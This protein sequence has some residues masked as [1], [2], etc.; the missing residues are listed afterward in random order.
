MPIY[1]T[2]DS[3]LCRIVSSLT[4]WITIS[5][6]G[7]KVLRKAT[8]ESGRPTLGHGTTV[9]LTDRLRERLCEYWNGKGEECGMELGDTVTVRS[10][11]RRAR[12]V[13]QIGGDR[14]RV[15]FTPEPM[16][17][18]IDR[19]TPQSEDEGGIYHRDDLEPF[20]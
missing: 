17:D 19:D 13:E 12:I 10:S 7:V 2:A 9:H 11:G 6:P 3:R 5:A 1:T 14:Y 16:N 18:P 15:E 20:E 8:A 4:L